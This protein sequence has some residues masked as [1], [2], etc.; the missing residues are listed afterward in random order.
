MLETKVFE[1]RDKGTF[2][3]IIATRLQSNDLEDEKELYLL[4]RAGFANADCF[5]AILITRL[6]GGARAEVDPYSWT[7][8]TFQTAH[9]WLEKNFHAINNG[10]VI[11]CE[12]IL[13]ETDTPKMSEREDQI[14]NY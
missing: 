1:L 12:F 6:S 7:D 3:P 5:P 13:G 11:D 9:H 4:R 8:R 2:I 14:N 10:D